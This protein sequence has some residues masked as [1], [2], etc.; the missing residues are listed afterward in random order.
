MS[1]RKINLV[2][3]KFLDDCD[4]VFWESG[5]KFIENFGRKERSDREIREFLQR[6]EGK[7]LIDELFVKIP[8]ET[9]LNSVDFES[10]YNVYW[11]DWEEYEDIYKCLVKLVEEKINANITEKE[12]SDSD[13]ES[14]VPD[15]FDNNEKDSSDNEDDDEI[16]NSIN[17]E[18]INNLIEEN[19]DL[20][21][22]P[23]IPNIKISDFE[24]LINYV[25]KIKVNS[26]FL[27]QNTKEET[28]KNFVSMKEFQTREGYTRS[29][30]KKFFQGKGDKMYANTIVHFTKN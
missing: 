24:R 14:N 19:I 6:D 20:P 15:E 1:V 3:F 7:E 27:P 28:E 8:L 21:K 30:V 4:S 11:D 29:S 23:I 10:Y 18:V 17:D 12:K 5:Y 22:N 9:K 16:N 26:I 2:P 13:I 25:P